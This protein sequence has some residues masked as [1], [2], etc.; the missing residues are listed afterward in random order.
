M[1]IYTD[2]QAIE[3]KIWTPFSFGM[4]LTDAQ[5][6]ERVI[7]FG[8]YAGAYQNGLTYLTA[9][10]AFELDL[11]VDTYNQGMAELDATEQNALLD[12]VTRRYL[13]NIDSILHD[14]K[15][16]TKQ[17]GITADSEIWDAKIAALAADR[18]AVETIAA[19]L[20]AKQREISAKIQTLSAQ[21]ILENVALQLVESDVVKSE[22]NVAKAENRSAGKD[23]DLARKNVEITRNEIAVEHKDIEIAQKDLELLKNTSQLQMVELQEAEINLKM[24][25]TGLTVLRI[26]LQTIEA[27]LKLLDVERD[28]ANMQIQ[29]VGFE[30]DIAKTGMIQSD[31]VDAQVE[32]SALGIHS[33]EKDIES[34]E[35]D[36][37]VVRIGLK[38]TQI[39]LDYAETDKETAGIAK[40]IAQIEIDALNND[41]LEANRDAAAAEYDGDVSKLAIYPQKVEMINAEKE[42]ID[43]EEANVT[44]EISSYDALNTKELT[45]ETEKNQFKVEAVEQQKTEK[46]AVYQE[47]IDTSEMGLDLTEATEAPL[48]ALTDIEIDKITRKTYYTEKIDEAHVTNMQRLLVAKIETTVLH[49]VGKTNA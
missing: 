47:R 8:L 49:K 19:K 12:I 1:T 35:L 3:R 40:T 13:L 18:L 25:E 46:L 20:E 29:E 2:Y 9:Y 27:G 39:D 15:M 22:L 36:N 6:T 42:I 26:Q 41:V 37:E 16:D 5:K 31:L 43:T 23:A 7:I 38:Q 11:I 45:N 30:K 17:A 10:S 24:T 21:I 32:T 28:A 44:A 4:R 48:N 33:A 14:Q 34:Q